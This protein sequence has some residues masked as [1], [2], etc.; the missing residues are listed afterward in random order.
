[1]ASQHKRLKEALTKPSGLIKDWETKG[2]S[3]HAGS[4]KQPRIHSTQATPSKDVPGGL[5]DS[6]LVS[7]RPS[8]K[9]SK[10]W[11]VTRKNEA[12]IS[13]ISNF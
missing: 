7:Q 4:S 9:E 13:V 2:V 8:S 11:D 6:D 5:T 12:S 10:G 3:R 1:M